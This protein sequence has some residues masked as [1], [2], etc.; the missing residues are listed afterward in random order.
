MFYFLRLEW[1][2][3]RY[4]L[5]FQLLVGAYLVLLPAI[6]LAGKKLPSLPPPMVSTDVL[7]IFPSIWGFLG[8]IG[9]WLSFFMFGFLAIGLITLEYSYRTLRQNVITGLDRDDVLKAKLTFLLTIALG[10]TLYYAICAL[11]IGGWH[12]ES[13]RWAK[14]WQNDWLI[15]RFFVMNMGYMIFGFTLG[16]LIRHTGIALFVYFGYILFLEPVIRW[17]LHNNYFPGRAMH[18]YPMNAVEDL[19][20]APQTEMAEEFIRKQGFSLFLSPGEALL[21][22]LLFSGLFLW[23]CYRRLQQADL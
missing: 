1:Y 18:Y 3:W 7:Y 8:Y 17:A 21:L 19:V 12:T 14:I 10:A 13:L 11:V 6:L 22:T 23:F 15:P 2:K 16:L 4:N 20:P 5:F 9:S